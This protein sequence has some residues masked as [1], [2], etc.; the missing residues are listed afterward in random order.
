MT[1]ELSA[2]DQVE[3]DPNPLPDEKGIIGTENLNQVMQHLLNPS[4][5]PVI[6]MGRR[7]HK[8]G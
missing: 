7:F 2:F 5:Q 6:R 4:G 8:G 1:K 3:G